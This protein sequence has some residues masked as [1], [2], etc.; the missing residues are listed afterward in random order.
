MQTQKHIHKV[1]FSYL[2]IIIWFFIIVFVIV[3]LYQ[4]VI[5][6]IDAKSLYQREFEK[7]TSRLSELEDMIKI[8][9][10]EQ[11]EARE[12]IETLSKEFVKADVFSYIHEHARSFSSRNDMI[13]IRDM[14]F[15]TSQNTDLWFQSTA[16]NISLLVSSERVLF[17]FMN[18]LIQDDGEYKFFI[19]N[20]TYPLGQIDG[21]FSVQIPLILYHR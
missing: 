3:P 14:S 10:D 4:K 16:I 17:D 11:S 8:I 9:Q 20:F 13:V 5:V 19:S 7:E 2:L 12:K 21:N 1:F 6:D 18:Y 15:N